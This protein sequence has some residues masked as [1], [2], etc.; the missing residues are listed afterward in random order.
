MP[1][2]ALPRPAPPGPNAL[3]TPPMQATPDLA[4][5]LAQDPGGIALLAYAVDTFFPTLQQ[6]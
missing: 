2:L 5:L 1:R 4:P 6:R 3:R